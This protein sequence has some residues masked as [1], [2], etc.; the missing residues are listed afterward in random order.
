MDKQKWAQLY[1]DQGDLLYE[2]M[3]VNNKPCGPGVVYFSNGEIYQEGIF[4]V[5]GLTI[6]REYYPDGKLRFE[7]IYRINR[8]YGPNYP[9]HGRF[10]NQDGQC[11]VEGKIPYRISGLGYP[12][13]PYDISLGKVVQEN[14]PK[15][16]WLM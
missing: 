5:K 7:G 12:L 10:F 16:H 8:G 14:A 4:G 1:S 13:E 9:E 15:Y 11:L 6:G 3:T 2:G